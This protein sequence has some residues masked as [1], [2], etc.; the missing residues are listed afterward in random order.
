M[1]PPLIFAGTPEPGTANTYVQFDWK[2]FV[3]PICGKLNEFL[4]DQWGA[5]S[6]R[7]CENIAKIR[8]Y[9]LN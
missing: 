6:L 7:C 3:K 2:S 9:Y 8:L 1:S 4:V 5:C